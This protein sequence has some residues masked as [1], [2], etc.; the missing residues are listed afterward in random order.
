MTC[1]P[2]FD[3]IYNNKNN[4]SRTACNFIKLRI[5]LSEE[6]KDEA[7]VKTFYKN[8]NKISRF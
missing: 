8:K 1:R 7:V 2:R 5:D 3:R 4:V 6:R